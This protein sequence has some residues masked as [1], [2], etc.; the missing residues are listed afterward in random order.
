MSRS[1]ELLG[2][3][4][5]NRAVVR[6]PIW[7]YRLRLGFLFG[8]RM[9]LLEHIGRKSGARR[10]AVLEVV[11]HPGTDEYVIVSGF[12]EKAQWYRNVIANPRVRVSVGLRRN[13]PATATPLT[14][15]AVK[16]T[17]ESYA[18]RHPRTWRTLNE[19]MA[20]ALDTPDLRLPMV[21]LELARG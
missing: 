13:V 20:A 16:E 8:H 2:R 1:S 19:A 11:D 15:E 17:V 6:A 18:E 21:R 10:Y 12:G 9:L 4:L 7:L 3:L 14:P 5:Q